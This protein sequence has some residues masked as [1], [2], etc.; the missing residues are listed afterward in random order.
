[1]NS[2]TKAKVSK[3]LPTFPNPI[4]DAEG[5]TADVLESIMLRVPMHEPWP[6]HENLDP[7]SFVSAKTDIKSGSA[8]NNPTAWKTYTSP[9]DTFKQNK[10]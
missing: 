7:A 4:V 6:H 3:A 5:N 10:G 8:I 9:D 1:M 2:D